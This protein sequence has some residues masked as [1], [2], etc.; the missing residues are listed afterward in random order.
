MLYPRITKLN[1]KE[2]LVNNEEMVG[3]REHMAQE[4]RTLFLNGVIGMKCA[5][6][7]SGDI[8]TMGLLLAL[9]EFPYAPIKLVINSLGGS[10][11]ATFL[12]I[13][14]MKIIE[15]PVITMGIFSA[16]AACLLLAAGSKRYLLSHSKTMLHLATGQMG[17]DYKD[18]AIQHK[19]MVDYQEKIIDILQKSGVKRN[20]D[21]ILEDMDREFWLEPD[22]AIEYGLADEI[23]TPEKWKEM[24]DA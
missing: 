3:Y 2:A 22:E 1:G 5:S 7:G 20:R 24:R 19:Q 13:D 8:E 21:E 18:F 16:S 4:H 9:D 23:F 6:C 17:G 10:L 15:S 11:D 14:I 12:L